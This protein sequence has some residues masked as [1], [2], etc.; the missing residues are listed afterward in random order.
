MTL[1]TYTGK[2]IYMHLTN[3]IL[4]I[5]YT[6]NIQHEQIIH[7]DSFQVLKLGTHTHSV[8]ER[9]ALLLMHH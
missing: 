6:I 5:V 3:I 7:N 1:A 8:V 9:T 4:Y 2:H